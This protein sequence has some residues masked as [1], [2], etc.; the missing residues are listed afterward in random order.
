MKAVLKVMKW[1]KLFQVKSQKAEGGMLNKRMCVLQELG[2][3]WEDA[4]VCAVFGND[5]LLELAPGDIVAVS[6]RFKVRDANDGSDRVYQDCDVA[7]IRK[8]A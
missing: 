1:D 3:Q 8:I 6:L 2:G 4:F 5:A 7:E